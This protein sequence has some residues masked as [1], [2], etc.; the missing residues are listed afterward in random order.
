MPAERDE[1][2]QWVGLAI[3]AVSIPC[4]A[5]SVV[6]AR[7][8]YEHGGNA[9]A[10]L[11]LRMGFFALALFVYFRMTGQSPWLPRRECLASLALGLLSSAQSFAYYTAFEYIPVS[12]AALL[13]H[14]YPPIVAVATRLMS[15]APLTPITV[16]ALVAA[17]VGIGLVL[18]VSFSTLSPI[19]LICGFLAALGMAATT[20]VSSRILARADSRRMTFHIALAAFTI[21]LIAA[22][23]TGGTEWPVGTAGWAILAAL[24]IVYLAASLGWYSSIPFLGPMKVALLSNMEPIF[25]VLFAALL[26]GEFLSPQQTAGAVLVIGAIFAVQVFG[27]RAA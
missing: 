14:T 27:R 18:Q 2:R 4:Y 22:L 25:T 23:T 20:L 1:S 9:L 11:V 6:M 16:G 5:L 12:L 13:L 19:G 26:L 15:R 21:Y 24:P 10:V 8:V 17:F 7:A 3:L